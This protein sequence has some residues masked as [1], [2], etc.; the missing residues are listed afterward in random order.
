MSRA[1][2]QGLMRLAVLVILV[3]TMVGACLYRVT[4]SNTGSATSASRSP[5]AAVTPAPRPPAARRAAGGPAGTAP[6]VD[7]YAHARAG[8]L[9]SVVR[10][11]PALVYV[12]NLRDGTVSVIDQRTLRVVNTY[13]TGS[14]PQH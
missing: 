9:S 12:P 8:M 1:R 13:A 3:V 14:E 7:V 4:G 10:D 5:T 11:D 6:A 2:R